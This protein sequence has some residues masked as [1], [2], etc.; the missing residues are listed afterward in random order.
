MQTN[1]AGL[2]F[3]KVPTFTLTCNDN[4]TSQHRKTNYIISN[5]TANSIGR[6]INKKKWTK[7][8]TNKFGL[9]HN[10]NTKSTIK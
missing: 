9:W 10:V 7:Y 4:V 8:W 1:A 6:H 2:M 5:E 3:L